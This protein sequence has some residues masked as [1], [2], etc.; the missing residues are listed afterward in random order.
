MEGEETIYLMIF[1]S[2]LLLYDFTIGTAISSMLE[3]I[4]AP[5]SGVIRALL[6]VIVW[7]LT[8][9]LNVL[10]VVLGLLIRNI[11]SYES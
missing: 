8:T 6:D 2:A 3:P 11:S 9:P 4:I 1:V 10:V 5:H 7:L